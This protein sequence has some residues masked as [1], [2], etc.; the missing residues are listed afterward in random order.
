MGAG[1][2]GTE[3]CLSHHPK[4][5]P[6]KKTPQFRKNLF[7]KKIHGNA[8][9][10]PETSLCLHPWGIRGDIF[11]SRGDLNKCLNSPPDPRPSA[12]GTACSPQGVPIPVEEAVAGPGAAVPPRR[13]AELCDAVGQRRVTAPQKWSQTCGRPVPPRERLTLGLGQEAP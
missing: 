1:T 4:L 7:P 2:D 8:S 5:V 9:N 13:G 11:P 10:A 12:G 3:S 6:I